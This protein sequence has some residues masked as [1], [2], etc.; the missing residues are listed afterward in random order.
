MFLSFC[1]LRH[2]SEALM[3]GMNSTASAPPCTT[4]ISH[5]LY[6]FLAFLAATLRVAAGYGRSG[7]L[8][9]QAFP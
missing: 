2:A 9:F 6:T 8:L 1:A 5:Q 3:S 7:A 4:G